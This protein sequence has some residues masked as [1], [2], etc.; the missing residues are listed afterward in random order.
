MVTYRIF[1][2]YILS[3]DCT[4]TY[5]KKITLLLKI[6]NE[7][8]NFLHAEVNYSK[9]FPTQLKWYT[10]KNGTTKILKVK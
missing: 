1:L 8:V 6:A 4:V 9:T 5:I 10:I 3:L 7:L 2:N